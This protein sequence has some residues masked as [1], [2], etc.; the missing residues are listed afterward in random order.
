MTIQNFN[1]TLFKY[2]HNAT[3]KSI[4]FI[5]LSTLIL[6]THQQFLDKEFRGY[7]KLNDLTFVNLAKFYCV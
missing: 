6:E 3:I 1:K 7:A 2:F 5:I 4:F